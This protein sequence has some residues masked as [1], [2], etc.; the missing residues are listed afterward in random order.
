MYC[1]YVNAY[2]TF[3]SKQDFGMLVCSCGL[4][5]MKI[6]GEITFI[7]SLIAYRQVL[8]TILYPWANRGR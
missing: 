1:E 5:L 3:Y 6:E 8:V 7:F 2:N 4:D